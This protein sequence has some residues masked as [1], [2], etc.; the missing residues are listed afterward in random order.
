LPWLSSR[1]AELELYGIMCDG[2]LVLGCTELNGAA[3]DKANLDTQ[4]GHV[5]DMSSQ[6]GTPFFTRRY[7]VHICPT[8]TDKPRKFTPEIQYYTRC[9]SG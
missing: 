4:N 5:H 6:A 2:T 1:Q 7:H 9:T 8:W 3:P